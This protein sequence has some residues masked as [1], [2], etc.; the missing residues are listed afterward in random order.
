MLLGDSGVGKTSVSMRLIDDRFYDCDGCDT[1]GIDYGIKSIRIKG[2][3]VRLQIWDM[4]GHDRF[5]PIALAY[6]ENISVIIIVYDISVRHTFESVTRYWLP[7]I[8]NDKFS[9]HK[10]V[11][12]VGN[13]ADKIYNRQVSI[14][15]GQSLASK[16]KLCFYE[17]SA[18]NGTLI[19][20]L[21]YDTATDLLME[22][23]E[24]IILSSDFR[25][26]GITDDLHLNTTPISK[27]I[28]EERD[29]SCV[30]Q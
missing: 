6:L 3:K 10:K 17:T 12:L 1:I 20:N 9:C 29:C 18:Y 30:L 8:R 22:I 25:N 5:L 28:T 21:F 24:N 23:H 2:K 7:H 27:T 14:E 15:E 4:A 19:E 16:E 11:I 26:M 13:K